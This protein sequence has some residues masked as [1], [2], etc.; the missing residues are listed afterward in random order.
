MKKVLV[1]VNKSISLFYFCLSFSL[2]LPSCAFAQDSEQN[3]IIGEL[4][5]PRVNRF[6]KPLIQRAYR[7]IGIA[8]TFE[9]VGG[10]RGLRLLN[11]GMTDADVI[12]YDVVSQPDNNI[13]IVPPALSHG[14]SFLLCIRGAQCDKSVIQNPT[15]AIAVTTRFFFNMHVSPEELNANIFEF[16]DFNHVINL[17]LNGR[18]DYAILPSDY[19]EKAIFEQSGIEYIPLV[20][21]ELVHV[22]H[23]KHAH[24]IDRLS[25]SIE[26]QLDLARSNN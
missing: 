7:D 20:E 8:V 13:I 15:K 4:N 9:K 25:A 2:L 10:E 16:D 11:E 3:F 24:L 6:Y 19:S 17:L 5:H 21:H 1:L 14:A 18:F 26:N 12:R 22:I 23:K